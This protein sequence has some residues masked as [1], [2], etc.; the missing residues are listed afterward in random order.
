MV[1]QKLKSKIT[2]GDN[3]ETYQASEGVEEINTEN[4]SILLGIIAQLRPGCDLSRITLPTFILEKK[5]MLERITNAFMTPEILIEANATEDEVDRFLKIVKWYLSGWHIAPKAVKKP[6]NPVLGEV[7]SCYWNKLPHDCSAYYV[8]EQTSH[9]PPESSYFYLIPEQ[10]IRADG[11]L[12][13]K[14]KFLG[15]SSA[16]MMEG[17]ACLK[18]GLHGGESYTV[19]QPNIYCRGILFGKLRYELGDHMLVKCEDTGLE[20]D[21]EFK[22]KGFLS[23][24]YDTIEGTVQRGGKVLYLISGKWN[25]LMEIQ[26]I[27]T[28]EKKTFYDT[29]N[30]SVIHAHVKQLEKQDLNESQRLWHDTI[31]ALEKGDHETATNKKFDV[32]DKQREEAKERREKGEEFVPKLFKSTADG[33]IPYSINAEIDILEDSPETMLAKLFAVHQI[34]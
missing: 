23:G 21:I 10:R 6:L 2:R 25:G 3:A 7:F 13:P 9:H 20:A 32:E 26:E 11:V 17:V 15:N 28:G 1:L 19:T 31:S 4:Q 24:E 8:A 33:E 22:T 16:A 14:S 5:S 29:S 30:S 18:L 27:A 34:H 12:I